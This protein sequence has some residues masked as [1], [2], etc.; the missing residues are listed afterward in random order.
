MKE[1]YR[2]CLDCLKDGRYIFW[3]DGEVPPMVGDTVEIVS[4]ASCEVHRP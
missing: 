4:A 1:T 3:L 2:L